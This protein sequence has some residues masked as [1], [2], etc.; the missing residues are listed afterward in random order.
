MKCEILSRP[1]EIMP[2][3]RAAREVSRSV[4]TIRRWCET[5]GICRQTGPGAPIE[6]NRVGLEMVVH[7]DNEA[8]ELLKAGRRDDPQVQRYLGHLG[9]SA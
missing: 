2:L 6:V 5:R 9:L 3:K 7:G 4:D 8:L 1:D